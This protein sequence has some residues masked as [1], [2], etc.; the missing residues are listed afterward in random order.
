MPVQ[1]VVEEFLQELL[2]FLDIRTIP[3]VSNRE[4]RPRFVNTLRAI[5]QKLCSRCGDALRDSVNQEDTLLSVQYD[6][7]NQTVEALQQDRAFLMDA[8][9]QRESDCALLESANQKLKESYVA[10]N[11]QRLNERK[12]FLRQIFEMEHI[13]HGLKSGVGNAFDNYSHIPFVISPELLTDMETSA[14]E[15]RSLRAQCQAPEAAVAKVRQECEKEVL[16]WQQKIEQINA[17]LSA[18]RRDTAES[19][20]QLTL[21]VD[22]LSEALRLTNAKYEGL[23]KDAKLQEVQLTASKLEI[24]SLKQMLAIA[25]SQAFL[26]TSPTLPKE[27]KSIAFLDLDAV[28]ANSIRDNSLTPNVTSMPVFVPTLPLTKKASKKNSPLPSIR[29]LR[30]SWGVLGG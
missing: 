2:E 16:R 11:N 30:D 17:E 28:T 20:H 12:Q 21:Q 1:K 29:A 22:R 13:I 24:V 4:D 23:Q 18:A 7:V 3:T 5:C 6:L 9:K 19:K 15:I 10:A 27:K 14:A 8:L 25:Q 26:E